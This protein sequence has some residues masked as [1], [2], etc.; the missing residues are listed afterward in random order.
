M[1]ANLND[2]QARVLAF[3]IGEHPGH[4][5]RLGVLLDG[6]RVVAF[7]EG[8]CYRL[9][10]VDPAPERFDYD[11]WRH[12]GWY[13]NNVRYPSG[14][15][16]CVSRKLLAVGATTLDGRWRIACDSRPE[17]HSY[18]CRDDAARAECYLVAVG[19]LGD[20]AEPPPLETVMRL[21][22]QEAMCQS[23]VPEIPW[24]DDSRWGRFDVV[25][26]ERDPDSGEPPA[27]TLSLS[28]VFS[29]ERF[30]DRVG[31]AFVKC[32]DGPV[33]SAVVVFD[34]EFFMQAPADQLVAP[35]ALAGLGS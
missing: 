2:A 9:P 6:G 10:D 3:L 11:W 22:E 23:S 1:I 19:A 17:D 8:P 18:A 12:G 26:F 28:E 27:G 14:A 7:G 32:A 35:C 15:V 25:A 34:G 20:D 5:V 33:Q 16:G 4:R 30:T 31:R 29:P 24:E 13:V 21:A